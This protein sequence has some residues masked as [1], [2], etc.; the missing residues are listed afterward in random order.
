MSPNM[1][2]AQIT[3]LHERLSQLGHRP[4]GDDPGHLGP[5][6]RVAIEAFQRERGLLVTGELDDDTWQRLVEAGWSL[7]SR[8]LFLTSP[9]QRGDDVADLQESLALLGFNPGRIDGIFGP[10]TEESLREFQKNTALVVDGTLTLA[11]LLELDRLGRQRGER[12]PVTEARDTAGISLPSD[13]A[14]VVVVGTSPLSALLAH[15]LSPQLDVR[16]LTSDE[17]AAAMANECTASV[18]INIRESAEPTLEVHYF[19]SYRSHS[20]VGKQLALDFISALPNL[21]PGRKVTVQGMSLPIL[22][23]TLMTAV[24]LHVG[25]L[26]SAELLDIARGAA[27]SIQNLFVL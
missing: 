15:E 26:T 7:G 5:A 24:D 20:V 3:E 11:T 23:E 6:T 22:R 12:R 9:Y 21:A 25:S 19:E 1:T 13:K 8:L 18:L 16:R 27:L 17:G 2:T 4:V 14:V 10:M